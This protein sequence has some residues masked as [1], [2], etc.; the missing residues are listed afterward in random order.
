MKVILLQD[1]NKIG[2]KYEVKNVSDGHARNLLIPK[3]L[4]KPATK[5]ALEW[6]EIQKEILTKNAEDDL[7]KTEEQVTGVDGMEVIMPV[8]IGDSGELFES[9][10]AQKISER[11]KELGFQIKKNQID[12]K[13]PIKETGEFPLKVHFAHN[14]E[15]E[16]KVIVQPIAND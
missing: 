8:K 12:L 4:V 3:G 14:L 10:N 9:I 5:E 11:L 16:I 15:A 1:I 6:L 13:D 7:K 2:K